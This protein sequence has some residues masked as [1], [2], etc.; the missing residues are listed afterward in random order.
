VDLHTSTWLMQAACPFSRNASISRSR[1]GISEQPQN[2]AISRSCTYHGGNRVSLSCRSLCSSS[3]S[4]CGGLWP[5][6]FTPHSA[7]NECPVHS[8]VSATAA[9]SSSH[10]WLWRAPV[11]S[12]PATDRLSQHVPPAWSLCLTAPS[13]LRNAL[14]TVACY[15]L[16]IAVEHVQHLVLAPWEA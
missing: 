14:S 5:V 6:V 7:E 15:K 16:F 2:C 1:R 9:I 13:F 12:G 11:H 10:C 4:G 8:F 3:C